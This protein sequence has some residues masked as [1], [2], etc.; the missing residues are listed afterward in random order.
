MKNGLYPLGKITKTHGYSGVLVIVS[1]KC[2]DDDLEELNEIFLLI[3]GL[4]VPF[5]VLKLELLTDTSA[6][7]QLEFVNN[8]TEALKLAG[9]EAFAAVE[10]HEQE[11]E[12][13]LDQW[14]G[15]DVHDSKHGKAG[16]I[17]KIEN[18]SGNVVIQIID[19]NRETLISLYPELVTGI[20]ND[21]KILYIAAPDGYFSNHSNNITL[22]KA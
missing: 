5:P 4:H 8:Q 19:G 6:H 18:Y 15:F 21:A 20:D 3:D 17:Q 10:P 11:T 12:P 22:K 7:V 14:I 9:C 13:G 2:L 1:D 16:V